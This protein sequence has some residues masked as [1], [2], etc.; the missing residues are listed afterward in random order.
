MIESRNTRFPAS[1]F[2]NGLAK[3]PLRTHSPL[4]CYTGSLSPVSGIW[5]ERELAAENGLVS[6]AWVYFEKRLLGF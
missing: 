2:G 3:V 6:H 5:V 1:P 4:V